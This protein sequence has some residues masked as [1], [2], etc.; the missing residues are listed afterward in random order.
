[1]TSVSQRRG[2]LV[3]VEH[4]TEFFPLRGGILQ[5]KVGR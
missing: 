1:M 2:P 4:L 5:R 3:Q